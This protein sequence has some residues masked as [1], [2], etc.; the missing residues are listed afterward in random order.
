MMDKTMVNDLS[1]YINGEVTSY[2]LVQ[3][4]ELR[5]G[6]N[7][8]YVRLRLADKTGSVNANIWKNAKNLSEKF[9]EGDIVKVKA[10]VILY[11]EQLQLTVNQVRKADNFEY[12]LVEFV[13]TTSSDLNQ[14]SE[15]F[16]GYI[17]AIENPHVKE[18]L[19]SIFEDKEFFALFCKSPAAKTWH[20]NYMGGLLEHSV[21]V[22]QICD[23]AAGMYPVDKDILMAG[24]LLHDVGK[25]LEYNLKAMIEFTTI[26]RLVGHLCIGDNIICEKAAQLDNFP[27]QILMKIRHLILSHHGEYEKAAAR[28]P[29]MIEA[30]VLHFA[31]NLDAQTVGVKQVIQGQ[32]NDSEWSEF[33]RLN[34]RYY[35]LG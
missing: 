23:H 14:L 21:C 32:H 15:Q 26:G 29:Q 20:H 9:N 1:G 25:V 30:V 24:A 22:A 35:Y 27:P 4:K 19:S 7:D 31:D 13:A 2:F 34:S 8:Y 16:F 17:E 18:L 6:K 28:L 3:Q 33:D 10:V 12:D 11:K 5:E